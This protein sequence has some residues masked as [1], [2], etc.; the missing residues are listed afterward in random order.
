MH[1][2]VDAR[3]LSHKLTGIGSYC[4]C[5]IGALREKGV[6]LT[7]FSHKKIDILPKELQ[8][9]SVV[10]GNTQSMFEG[11]MWY[12][13]ELPKHL[14]NANL[15]VFWGAGHRFPIRIPSSQ[16]NAL[17]IHD[18]TWRKAPRTMA[19]KNFAAEALYMPNSLRKA[20]IILA[21]SISTASQLVHYKKNLEYKVAVIHG[22]S[23]LEGFESRF[24]PDPVKLKTRGSWGD[25]PQKKIILA[26][27]T[28]EPRKN[29]LR[30]LRAIANLPSRLQEDYQLIIAGGSGWGS[31]REIFEVKKTISMEIVFTDFVDQ[32]DLNS[33]YN[34]SSVFVFPSLY[35]GF[36]I[37]ILEA[38]EHS[39][40]VITSNTSSMPEVAGS[41]ALLVNPYDVSDITKNIERLLKSDSLQ[42]KLIQNGLKNRERYSWSRTADLFLTSVEKY[43]NRYLL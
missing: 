20:D 8:N 11:L 18:L 23:S 21:T 25:N 43:Q 4:R 28:I 13:T 15:D 9:L 39:V 40:P 10:S 30:L 34:L 2:G 24:P 41:G 14:L 3:S 22:S 19:F 37:P 38:Q 32:S 5:L 6:K 36:G 16:I 33:L 27:G 29:L 12:E 42:K 17:T 31:Q 35:E 26:V 7:L 1:I